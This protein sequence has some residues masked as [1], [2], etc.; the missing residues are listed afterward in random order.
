MNTE[1]SCGAVVF[2]EEQ[3]CIKYLIIQSNEGI[4]GFPKGHMESGEREEE[5]ALREIFEET[6][7]H[8]RLLD[9]F[10]TEDV[11]PFVNHGQQVMKHIVYFLAEYGMQNPIAQETE[12]N[13]L[14][15]MEYDFAM[16]VFQYD[17][18][19]RILKEAHDFLMRSRRLHNH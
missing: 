2:T 17:S 14:F 16:E 7:V 4:Y 3:G 18:T 11:H 12:L 5:T 15:L 1:K 13:G 10:R 6:G 8:V 9:G 19:R